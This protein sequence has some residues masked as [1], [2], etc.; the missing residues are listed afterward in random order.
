MENELWGK[1]LGMVDTRTQLGEQHC[2]PVREGAHRDQSDG[3]EADG[4]GHVQEIF[5]R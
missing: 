1:G 5:G 3:H 2:C 4:G